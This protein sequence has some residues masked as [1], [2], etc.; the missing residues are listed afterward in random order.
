M[1]GV[2][3]QLYHHL[4]YYY[5]QIYNTF[6]SICD[7]V[8]EN[9]AAAVVSGYGSGLTWLSWVEFFRDPCE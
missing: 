3:L 1:A 8:L 9:A 6:V 7:Y 5:L 2:S 4:V